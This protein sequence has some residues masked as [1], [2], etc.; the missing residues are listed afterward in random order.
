MLLDHESLNWEISNEKI[1]KE[2]TGKGDGYTEKFESQ[3]QS[4]S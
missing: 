1:H 4:E 3:D 2:V